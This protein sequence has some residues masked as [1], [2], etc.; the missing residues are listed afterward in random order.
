MLAIFIC[1]SGACNVQHSAT[2]HWS[3]PWGVSMLC[4][5]VIAIL[6]FADDANTFGCNI[7]VST[8]DHFKFFQENCRHALT[9][10]QCVTTIFLKN[11]KVLDVAIKLAVCEM[12]ITEYAL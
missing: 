4:V 6:T 9:N 11:L 12:H 8:N 10:D 7:P 1:L 3:S 5:R 2:L